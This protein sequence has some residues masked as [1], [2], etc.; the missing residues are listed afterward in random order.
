MGRGFD[1]DPGYFL[2][3]AVAGRHAA[4]LLNAGL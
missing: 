2:A 3:A 4:T 1:D